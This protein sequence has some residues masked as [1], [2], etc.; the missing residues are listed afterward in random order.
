MLNI[1]AQKPTRYVSR[2]L[3]IA[4]ACWMTPLEVHASTVLRVKT[5]DQEY[6]MDAAD[7][8]VIPIVQREPR[9]RFIARTDQWS[10][11]VDQS[12]WSNLLD[13]GTLAS[14]FECEDCVV[15]GVRFYVF[16]NLGV[17]QKRDTTVPR[18]ISSWP[19]EYWQLEFTAGAPAFFSPYELDEGT[20]TAN[21][22]IMK[23]TERENP[24]LRISRN[25]QQLIGPATDQTNDFHYTLLNSFSEFDSFEVL[26]AEYDAQ[27]N[28][29]KFAADFERRD[30]VGNSLVAGQLR[31]NSSV[32]IPEPATLY[33]L[34][35]SVASLLLRRTT[36]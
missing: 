9:G 15:T 26:E 2:L 27:G 12:S 11:S 21:S 6:R 34:L 24:L 25:G 22:P 18:V 19:D 30:A 33:L 3:A 20:Y 13:L 23:L 29:L 10:D 16:E 35:S 32:Q 8:W 17:D 1:N 31:H 7:A 36:N 4:V 14:S 28:L 5:N